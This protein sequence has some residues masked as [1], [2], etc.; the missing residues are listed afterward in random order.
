MLSARLLGRVQRVLGEE[1]QI[2]TARDNAWDAVCADRARAA[3]RADL[4]KRL[5]RRN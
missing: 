5:H 1:R 3:A 2:N 4:R